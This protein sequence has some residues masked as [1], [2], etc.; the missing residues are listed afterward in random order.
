M[1]GI[2]SDFTR[3][4]INVVDVLFGIV[5]ILLTILSWRYTRKRI[6]DCSKVCSQIATIGQR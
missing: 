2:F 3:D 6:R 1:E 5:G 4:V